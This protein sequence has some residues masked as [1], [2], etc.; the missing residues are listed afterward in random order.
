MLWMPVLNYFYFYCQGENL[1]FI[2]AD[3]AVNSQWT[4]KGDEI[5]SQILSHLWL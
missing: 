2:I 4:A 3:V 5:F 1:V